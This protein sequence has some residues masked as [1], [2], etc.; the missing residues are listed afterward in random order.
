VHLSKIWDGSSLSF[1]FPSVNADLPS[2]ISERFKFNFAIDQGENGMVLAHSNIV[3]GSDA[4]SALPDY[5]GAS[6]NIFA[7]VSFDAQ[8]LAGAIATVSRASSALLVRH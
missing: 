7:A 3:A 1:L 4:G 5:D 2:V 8:S 6:Q